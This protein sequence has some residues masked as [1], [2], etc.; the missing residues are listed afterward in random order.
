MDI[1]SCRL[2]KQAE[3]LLP[4]FVPKKSSFSCQNKEL[5]LKHSKGEIC[6]HHTSSSNHSLTDSANDTYS[7]TVTNKD[8]ST[9][10]RAA[11]SSPPELSATSINRPS[12]DASKTNASVKTPTQPSH[13]FVAKLSQAF[14]NMQSSNKSLLAYSCASM[15]SV[16]PISS[17]IKSKR[18]L[19]STSAVVKPNTI[20]SAEKEEHSND[21]TP[22]HS[23]T[24]E[25]K[26]TSVPENKLKHDIS[27]VHVVDII[28]I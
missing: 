1:V 26:P 20:T 11:I 25:E 6:L 27:K 13:P 8:S 28:K 24:K 17:S 5:Q 19:S 3:K 7:K 22:L 4:I 10:T 9:S 2:M 16:N 21:I 12:T 23:L 14:A 18:K 15:E